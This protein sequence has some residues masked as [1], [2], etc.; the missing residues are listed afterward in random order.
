MTHE[1]DFRACC[2]DFKICF[3]F[4]FPDIPVNFDHAATKGSES[5]TNN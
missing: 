4:A 3:V 5:V 1:Q 2:F